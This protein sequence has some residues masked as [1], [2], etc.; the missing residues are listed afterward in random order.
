MMH[1]TR[2]EEHPRRYCECGHS[3]TYLWIPE[4]RN[5]HNAWHRMYTKGKELTKTFPRDRIGSDGIVRV[6]GSETGMVSRTVYYLSRAFSRQ[7]GLGLTWAYMGEHPMDPTFQAY[8]YIHEQTRAVSVLFVQLDISLEDEVIPG[9]VCGIFTAK[10]YRGQGLAR[11]LTERHAADLG[12]SVEEIV[13]GG[14]LT[15]GGAHLIRAVSGEEAR[16]F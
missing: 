10:D 12:V 2:Q 5:Q 1:K 6:R 8:L 3:K 16:I 4:E 7:C 14:P 9:V 11:A 15:I 13:W